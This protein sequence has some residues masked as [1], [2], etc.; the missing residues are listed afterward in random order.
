M[1]TNILILGNNCYQKPLIEEALGLKHKV[2]VASNKINLINKVSK[3]NFWLVDIKNKK[4]LLSLCKKFNVKKI[5]TAGSDIGIKSMGFINSKL[6]LDGI[7]YKE[8]I[9]CSDK[10]Y[11]KKFM[12]RLQIRNPSFRIIKKKS[13]IRF[14]K[15]PCY[16]KVPNSSGSRG[17]EKISNKYE[18]EK[19]I[20]KNL[21]KN[22][23]LILEDFIDG[24][25][26][27]S[28]TVFKNNKILDII[29]HGDFTTNY[30]I[31]V[32]VGHI[33][34]FYIDSKIKK[35]IR[36]YSS[37][38][39]NNLSIKNGILNFDF[40]LKKKK[41]Y[42]IEFG[43]RLGATGIPEII[44][45][46]SKNNLW[47][48]ILCLDNKNYLYK[49]FK[50][51]NKFYYISYLLKSNKTGKLKKVEINKKKL[52]PIKI[53]DYSLDYKIGENIKKFTTGNDRIG[54]VYLK[55]KLKK[56]KLIEEKIVNSINV[57]VS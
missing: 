24:Y 9:I 30:P 41:L 36:N 26:F 6:K 19:F 48:S 55:T 32:P 27:G 12:N 47:K 1:K 5:L 42:V 49:K 7:K 25:E 11:M 13:N 50:L 20:I 14:I 46:S 52:E 3:K 53:L 57:S 37:K 39:I 31:S 8:S 44:N 16:I 35:Q 33:I 43:A 54:I 38:I 4:K 18:Y 28:Q 56:K 34:P 29:I 51:K 45:F 17:T 22:K 40:I 15:F 2:Y 10:I 23:K 21:K